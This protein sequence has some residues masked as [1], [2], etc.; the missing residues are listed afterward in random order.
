MAMLTHF[1][2]QAREVASSLLGCAIAWRPAGETERGEAI[3][4]SKTFIVVVVFKTSTRTPG[5]RRYLEKAAQVSRIVSWPVEP[6]L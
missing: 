3:S 5:R 2:A 1:I 6:E 4:R